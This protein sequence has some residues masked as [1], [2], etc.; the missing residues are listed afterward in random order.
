MSSKI[1]FTKYQ[2][3]SLLR[4]Q[5]RE[6]KPS[7]P[8]SLLVIAADPVAKMFLLSVRSR[9]YIAKSRPNASERTGVRHRPVEGARQILA[10]VDDIVPVQ[11]VVKIEL[12]AAVL[13]WRIG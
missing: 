13:I 2:S 12:K 4:V 5:K 11:Q 10:D 7:I 8:S 1:F 3:Y 6:W 9:L